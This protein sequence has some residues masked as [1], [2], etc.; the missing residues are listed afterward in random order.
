MTALDGTAV[1]RRATPPLAA[2]GVGAMGL[3]I[4]RTASVDPRLLIVGIVGL[5]VAAYTFTHLTGGLV[6]LTLVSFFELIPTAFG[7]NLTLVKVVGAVL[8]LAWI[9]TVLD[10]KSGIRV[11][12]WE[13]PWLTV[14]AI[15]FTL[16]GLVSGIWA[17]DLGET[18]YFVS[19][20]AQD[21]VLVF[22]VYS[23]VRTLEHARAVIWAYLCGT[24]LTV[25]YG[26]IKG[27]SAGS[28]GRLVGGLADPNFL[29]AVIVAA[30]V[31]SV[32]MLATTHGF[33]RLVLV[34]FLCL[35][36]PG[37]FMTGSRGGI[38]TLGVAILTAMVL[39]GPAR[40]QVVALA[41]VVGAVTV[42][43]YAIFAPAAVRDRVSAVSAADSAGRVDQYNIALQ[44]A[45]D[46][47]VTGVGLGN[48]TVVESDYITSTTTFYD[49]RALVTNNPVHNMYLSVLAELGI[50]G[51]ALL[52]TLLGGCLL[53][54]VKGYRERA[55]EGDV[56]G[57]LLGRGV[58]I[59][60]VAFLVAYALLPG[61]YDKQLWLMLG[62]CAALSGLRGSARATP[63]S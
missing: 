52:A 2:V 44:V 13:R 16:W 12:L 33:K 22:V 17:P 3:V 24:V 26:L 59:A 45:G 9:W 56:E 31:L 10:R 63:A 34:A 43:Y 25:A 4:G 49:V 18:M 46:H 42:G 47:P 5:A 37:L 57:E 15:A 27:L 14:S 19:R 53:S 41:L 61:L 32:V 7:G 39:A 58:V 29:A 30:I 51:I 1:L 62:L 55:R 54:G 8:T 21:A 20:L 23:A 35:F 60:T 11:M 28:S 40:A 36:L 38:I 6:L 50:V 48:F